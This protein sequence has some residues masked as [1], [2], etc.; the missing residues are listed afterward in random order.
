[1][2]NGAAVKDRTIG[3]RPMGIAINVVILLG[4]LLLW[5][6]LGRWLQS[7]DWRLPLWSYLFPAA[8][9]LFYGWLF[10]SCHLIDNCS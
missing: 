9:I 4:P 5:I 7:R 10:Y 8:W 1:M 6:G 3:T 2:Q